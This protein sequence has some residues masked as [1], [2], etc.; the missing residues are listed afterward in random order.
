LLEIWESQNDN[1][2][3][4]LRKNKK[5]EHL[6]NICLI[7]NYKYDIISD[8]NNLCNGCSI[9]NNYLIYNEIKFS[10]KSKINFDDFLYLANNCN[11][12][13]I[14]KNYSEIYKKIRKAKKIDKKYIFDDLI[15][16]WNLNND[17]F[18]SHLTLR[19]SVNTCKNCLKKKF[20]DNKYENCNKNKITQ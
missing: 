11:N 4:F 1:F 8:Y 6:C 13:Q 7:N 10:G 17:C 14:I 20:H 5:N 18:Y 12:Y 15:K 16:I 3:D 2:Y 9:K 19:Y